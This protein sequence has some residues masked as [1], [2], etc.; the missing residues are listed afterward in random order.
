MP[1]WCENKLVIAGPEN[2]IVAMLEAFRGQDSA[3]EETCL[4]DF[5]KIVPYPKHLAELDERALEQ[6]RELERLPKA[7]QA[8]YIAK[9][10]WPKDGY[11]QGGYEWC[12]KN[13]GTKCPPNARESRRESTDGCRPSLKR[14]GPRRFPSL[15]PHQLSFPR[16]NSIFGIATPTWN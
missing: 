3:D 15:Q 16:C 5:N 10:G 1:N 8:E 2:D 13:W 7:Q 14:H 11:S 4:F 6:R 9:H 12:I